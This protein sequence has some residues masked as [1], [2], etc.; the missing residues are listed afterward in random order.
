MAAYDLQIIVGNF[1]SKEDA[2]KAAKAIYE[3]IM[4]NEGQSVRVQ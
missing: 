3:F 4:G 1:A 2:Q